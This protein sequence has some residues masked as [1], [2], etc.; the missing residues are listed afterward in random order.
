MHRALR[1]QLANIL[2]T[3]IRRVSSLAGGCV[4]EVVRAEGADG[5]SVVVKAGGA[6]GALDIE[7]W[8]VRELAE[9]TALPVPRVLH[10]ASEMLVL[11]WV[12]ETTVDTGAVVNPSLGPGDS[13]NH[14]ADLLVDLYE[15]VPGS[16]S[17]G[18]ERETLIGPLPLPN[19]VMESWSAFFAHHRLMHFARGAHEAGQLDA[20]TLA[21]CERLAGDLDGV[22]ME[23]DRP[24]LLHGDVWSGNVVT[25]S[26]R[27]L[28]MIDPAIF[29]GDPECDLAF[30]ALF[31]TG[32]PRF[33]ER[34]H[35]RR[36]IGEGFFERRMLVY[37]LYPLLVH[38]HLFGGGYAAQ[39]ADRLTRLGY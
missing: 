20:S 34:F 30:I 15:V 38:A 8:M 4:A 3:E 10:A 18:L 14:L 11:A 2:G 13:G 21:R 16:C 25:G 19:P 23:P 17:F 35:E 29:R 5:Q 32:G 7:G 12:D 22:L 39:V 26:G 33:F 1:E 36:P 37:Q 31:D 27:V 6:G 24:S 9:R 28:A